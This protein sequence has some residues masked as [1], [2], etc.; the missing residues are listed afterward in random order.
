MIICCVRVQI[1]PPLSSVVQ[2]SVF[3]CGDDISEMLVIEK[4]VN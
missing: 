2:N 3:R 1:D 4:E